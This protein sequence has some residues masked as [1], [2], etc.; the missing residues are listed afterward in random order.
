[1][2]VISENIFILLRLKKDNISCDDP[3]AI[4]GDWMDIKE[5]IDI[6]SSMINR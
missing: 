4:I 3:G 5:N 2:S 6:I 1:M